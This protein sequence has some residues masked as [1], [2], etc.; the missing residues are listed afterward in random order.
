MNTRVRY[1]VNDV[2]N[3][4]FFQMPKFLFEGEFKAL[5]NNARVLYTL[6]RDRH[7]LSLQNHWVNEKN[8]VYLIFTRKNMEE[9]LGLSDK[10]V[11]KAVDELKDFGLIEEEHIGL[12]KANRIYLTSVNVENTGIGETPTPESEDLRLRNRNN[13]DSRNRDST[14]QETEI[15]RTNDTEFNNTDVNHTDI[16]SINHDSE[17]ISESEKEKNISMSN[18]DEKPKLNSV[19]ETYSIEYLREQFETAILEQ[20]NEIY[21]EL[22]ELIYDVVNYTGN[23]IKVNGYELPAETVKSRFLKLNV[24]H[25]QYVVNSLEMQKSKIHNIRQYLITTLYNSYTTIGSYYDA[26]VRHDFSFSA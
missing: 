19:H 16:Q 26:A 21:K 23:T 3:N 11:K 1:T 8:E 6:L 20:N 7:D 22:T 10:T 5:S 17:E 18:L 14:I 24:G 12:N 15:L 9:M 4:R 13:Y 2:K 25:L